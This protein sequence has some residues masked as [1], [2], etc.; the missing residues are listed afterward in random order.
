MLLSFAFLKLQSARGG[1]R[2]ARITRKKSCHLENSWERACTQKEK[3]MATVEVARYVR[4]ILFVD[5]QT[6]DVAPAPQADMEIGQD[7]AEKVV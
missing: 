1:N 2:H 3:A 5:V 4:Q 6:P 7:I